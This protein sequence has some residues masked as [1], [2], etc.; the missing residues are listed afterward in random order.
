MGSE[1]KNRKLTREA[2]WNEDA[3]SAVM[4]PEVARYSVHCQPAFSLSTASSL[5]TMSAIFASMSAMF[6][7][8]IAV[9][10]SPHASPTTWCEC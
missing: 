8:W 2:V 4:L 3:G 6:E 5:S 10:L 7:S 1:E 9:D